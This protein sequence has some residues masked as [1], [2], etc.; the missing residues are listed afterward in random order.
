MFRIFNSAWESYREHSKL[1]S[2]KRYKHLTKLKLT[3]YRQW[4][5]G[6]Q[7]AGYATD[8]KYAIKLIE[9]IEKLKL[10]RFDQ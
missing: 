10:Y 4:A 2:T 9:I 3:D 1:L 6:L 8:K 7:N 5:I